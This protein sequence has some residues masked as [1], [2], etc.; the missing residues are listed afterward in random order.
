MSDIDGKIEHLLVTLDSNLRAPNSML[1]PFLHLVKLRPETRFT[2][3]IEPSA[4]SEFR[5]ILE[6]EKVENAGR[7]KIVSYETI[8]RYTRP[9]M[10]PQDPIQVVF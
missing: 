6:R 9:Y 2:V 8:N 3:V 5:K 4:I 1:S 7:I 10:W